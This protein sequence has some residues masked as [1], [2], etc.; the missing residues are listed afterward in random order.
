MITTCL[1]CHFLNPISLYKLYHVLYT[2]YTWHQLI[3]WSR[4]TMTEL[5]ITELTITADLNLLG[6]KITWHLCMGQSYFYQNVLVLLNMNITCFS[7]VT[8][9][10][11]NVMWMVGMAIQLLATFWLSYH[12]WQWM[13]SQNQPCRPFTSQTTSVCDL[14]MQ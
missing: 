13:Q 7:W 1:R 2:S 11:N 4:N 10:H 8:C 3:C 14:G 5:T 6:A 12:S 9:P